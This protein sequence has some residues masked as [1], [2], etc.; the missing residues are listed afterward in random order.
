M[1]PMPL[2]AVGDLWIGGAG[3]AQG[4]LGD[5]AQTAERFIRHPLAGGGRLY[6]TGDLASRDDQGNLH[7]HGR[8]DSQVKIRG[9]RI[10]L[11]EV[12]ATLAEAPGLSQCA[13]TVVER[14]GSLLLVAY[15]VGRAGCEIE[16]IKAHCAG[17]LPG[18]MVPDLWVSLERLP[19]TPNGKIDRA[20]LPAPVSEPQLQA[21]CSGTEAELQGIYS[22]LLE[23]DR[24][25]TRKGF[26]AIGGHSLLAMRLVAH[27]NREYA[28]DIGVTEFLRLDSIRAV[29]ARLD[30]IRSESTFL[31]I[32]I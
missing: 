31:E 7:F 9:Y 15:V 23:V 8:S 11:A 26:Y 6:K 14:G 27:I 32:V 25:D 19:M 20:A 3:V 29:A 28:T 10:E 18:Y 16:D 17:T 1:Q 13:V 5:A 24:V 30:E 12:E 21:P 4:Y 22:A 2:G